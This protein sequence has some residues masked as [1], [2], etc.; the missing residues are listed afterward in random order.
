MP[1]LLMKAVLAD[2]QGQTGTG[3]LPD[4][5]E[6]EKTDAGAGRDVERSRHLR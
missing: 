3:L 5:T 2:R 1:P 4:L 6:G